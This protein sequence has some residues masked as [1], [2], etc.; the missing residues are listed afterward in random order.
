MF[1]CGV[2]VEDLLGA[3]WTLW[4]PLGARFRLSGGVMFLCTWRL[5]SFPPRHPPSHASKNQITTGKTPKA[6]SDP[7]KVERRFCSPSRRPEHAYRAG[8][9]MGGR[10]GILARPV[11]DRAGRGGAH[12]RARVRARAKPRAWQRVRR[13]HSALDHGVAL[14]LPIQSPL[15]RGSHL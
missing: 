13:R 11:G 3:S 14:E 9:R 4:G 7:P 2:R 10:S 12:D 5:P 8:A 6:A 15:H 1:S